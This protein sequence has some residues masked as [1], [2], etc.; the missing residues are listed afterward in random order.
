MHTGQGKER[1]VQT[2]K[3]I[4]KS[5]VL[6]SSLPLSSCLS[7]KCCNWKTSRK[8]GEAKNSPLQV[9]EKGWLCLIMTQVRGCLCCSK[10][11]SGGTWLKHPWKPTKS[12]GKVKTWE[13]RGE[14]WIPGYR[15]P[16]VF[17]FLLH[18]RLPF[19]LGDKHSWWSFPAL[20]SGKAGWG[21]NKFRVAPPP[22][23]SEG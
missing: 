12:Q 10:P 11:P 4:L 1:A 19:Y 7:L 20:L 22:F 21:C 16:A 18:Y 17:S 5:P 8:L 13:V 3:K 2:Q 9:P 6:G 23:A 14:N 15:P